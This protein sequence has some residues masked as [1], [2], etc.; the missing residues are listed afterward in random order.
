MWGINQSNDLYTGTLDPQGEVAWKQIAGQYLWVSIGP[1]EVWATNKDNSIKSC[2]KPCNGQWIGVPGGLVQL[3]VGELEVWGVNTNDDIYV[4]GLPFSGWNLIGGKIRNISNGKSYVYGL[5]AG[6]NVFRCKHPCR[7][8]WNALPGILT[9]ISASIVDESV[10]GV[11]KA[12][13]LFSWN[14]SYWNI[15]S[16]GQLSNV[17]TINKNGILGCTPAGNIIYGQ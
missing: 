9:Q 4:S 1:N 8:V 14:G 6:G 11:T 10:F 17:H 7:G 2:K 12:N 3:S 5:N 15:I 16:A 13:E